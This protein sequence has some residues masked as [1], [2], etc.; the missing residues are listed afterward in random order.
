MIKTIMKTIMRTSTR[1]FFWCFLAIPF[2]AVNL[3]G[4][5]AT[6]RGV[7]TDAAGKPVRGAVVKATLGPKSISRFTQND[8]RY[9]IP[10][11]AGTYQ[12]SVDAY[13]YGVKFQTKDTAQPGDTNFS[14]TP[15]WDVTRLT[16]ASSAT[17][18]A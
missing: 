15:K 2:L 18:S 11:A 3:F 7:V 12:M 10:V 4:A 14:L 16:G 1:N 17:I 13:G 6:L 5:D 8:G 9:E